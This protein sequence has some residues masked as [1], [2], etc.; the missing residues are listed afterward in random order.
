MRDEPQR[1]KR[2]TY[3]T[4]LIK[5]NLSYTI[6][7]IAELYGLHTNA[8]RQW[9]KDGLPKIDDRKPFLI[10]GGDL[11]AFLDA[12]QTGRKRKCAP[13]ELYCCR[14]REPRRARQNLVSIEIRNE[15]QLTHSANCEECGTKMKQIGSVRKLDEYRSTFTVQTIE[16]R[17]IRERCQTS[18]MCHLDEEKTH[19]ELQPQK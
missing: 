10:H 9:I 19:A 6:Q 1:R 16:R 2:R 13:D 5:R 17:H 12:R 15:K 18:V 14:C 8:V 7:E 11:I 4:R 3:N